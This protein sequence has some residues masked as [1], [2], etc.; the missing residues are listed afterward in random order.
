M[1]EFELIRQWANE[2]G[3]YENGDVKT[4][5][6]KLQEE[7][8]ELAR[9]I[10]KKDYDEFVDAIGDCVV[11][12]TNLTELGNKYFEDYGDITIEK[13]IRSAYDVIAYRTGKMENGTFVKDK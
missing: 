7:T 3:I 6:V 13:C 5:F 11:V 8:G 9:S 12:L 2:R 1:K 10:I 4:Q